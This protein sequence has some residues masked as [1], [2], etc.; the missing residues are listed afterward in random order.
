[1]ITDFKQFGLEHIISI[2]IPCLLGVLFIFV[3]S[4]TKSEVKRRNIR[5]LLAVTIVSIRGARYIMDIFFGCFDWYDLFSLQI[6][7]IDLILLIICLIK[8]RDILFNFNFLMGIPMALAVA[9]FPGTNHP[10]PGMPRAMLFIM[11]HMMLAIGAIYLAAIEH[12]KPTLKFYLRFAAAGNIGLLLIY[13][14]N[15]ILNSNFLYIMK[16]PSGTVI[17]VLNN[18]FGWPGYVFVMDALA[19]VLMLVMFFLSQL[20]Y[21]FGKRKSIVEADNTNCR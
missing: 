16:A 9:F 11:S 12:K 7:H 20:F 5:I 4:R 2:I 21:M 19:L 3:G 18:I 10:A 17:D 14:V 8:P 1:M 6:C 15:L 13:F